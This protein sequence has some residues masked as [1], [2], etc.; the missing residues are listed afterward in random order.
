MKF[1]LIPR[2]SW[3]A[4]SLPN[5]NVLL[6]RLASVEIANTRLQKLQ[7][8]QMLQVTKYK[9]TEKLYI[10]ALQYIITHEDSKITELHIQLQAIC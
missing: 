5:S 3:E 8:L 10:I 4:A 7:R 2:R 6:H 9:I 1:G